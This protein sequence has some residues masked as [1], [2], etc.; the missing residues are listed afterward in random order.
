[1]RMDILNLQI[2]DFQSK[3]LKSKIY[4]KLYVE[5]QNTFVLKF[6]KI[7]NMGDH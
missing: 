6:C 3:T 4:V 1:M 5:V 7:E 2:S